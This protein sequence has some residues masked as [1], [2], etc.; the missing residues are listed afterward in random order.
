[1]FNSYKGRE[2]NLLEIGIDKGES[3]SLWK[4]LLP[5]ACIFGI[6]LTREC[7]KYAEGEKVKIFIG[8]QRDTDFLMRVVEEA[9]GFFDL[10]IDDCGHHSSEQI[11]CFEF[12]FKYLRDGGMY[13]VED[14]F[15]SYLPEFTTMTPFQLEGGLSFVDYSKSLIDD[16]FM[17]GKSNT[18]DPKNSEKIRTGEVRLTFMEQNVSRILYTS[19]LVCITKKDKLL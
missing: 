11:V 9:N 10:I 14:A 4:Y 5:K 15:T 18:A 7:A 16:V 1:M 19:G 12:L 3:I 17:R 6:D 8:N 2:I 13:I